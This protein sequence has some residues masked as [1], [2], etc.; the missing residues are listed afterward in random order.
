MASPLVAF[1][2]NRRVDRLKESGII[3]VSQTTNH[4]LL[5][6][7]NPLSRRLASDY[8]KPVEF[9]V[10]TNEGKETKFWMPCQINSFF[11]AAPTYYGF[12]GYE[13]SKQQLNFEPCPDAPVFVT[14]DLILAT[15]G[16]EQVRLVTK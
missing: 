10:A 3:V 15:E 12:G 6:G 2:L 16:M 11:N 5:F 9:H 8:Q 4:I 1:V 7:D 14:E 13:L